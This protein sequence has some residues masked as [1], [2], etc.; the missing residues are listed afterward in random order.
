MSV[1]IE[2]MESIQLTEKEKKAVVEQKR[3]LFA[4]NIL[5]AG[6]ILLVIVFVICSAVFKYPSLSDRIKLA[7]FVLISYTKYLISA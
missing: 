6:I 4:G 1:N 3:K 5:A 2:C 7:G